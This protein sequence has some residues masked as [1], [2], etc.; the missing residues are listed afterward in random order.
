MIAAVPAQA[1]QINGTDHPIVDDRQ[2]RARGS[3]Q[4][5]AVPAVVPPK[6]LVIRPVELEVTRLAVAVL[7]PRGFDLDGRAVLEGRVVPAR[8]GY[9]RCDDPDDLRDD[10]LL[11]ERGD[12]KDE[13]H[14]NI[15]RQ[16]SGEWEL[17]LAEDL[18]R[19]LC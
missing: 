18:W 16:D 4:N 6:L 9:D 12:L 13:H 5:E 10:G 3:V 1:R 11:D 19:I 2:P 7:D 14:V 17:T 8:F 15:D